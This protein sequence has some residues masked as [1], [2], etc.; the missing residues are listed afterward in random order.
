MGANWLHIQDGTGEAGTND[1]TVT[2]SQM[3]EVGATVV[4]EGVLVMDRDFGSGYKYA[5][6]IENAAVTIE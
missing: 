5:V 3:A 1:L 2:T 4:V 6:I